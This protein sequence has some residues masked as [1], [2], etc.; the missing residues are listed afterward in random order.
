M[1]LRLF[2][3]LVIWLWKHYDYVR[4]YIKVWATCMGHPQSLLAPSVTYKCM[5]PCTWSAEILWRGGAMKYK[6]W[7]WLLAPF[8]VI[9]LLHLL[10]K[11]SITKTDHKVNTLSKLI[12]GT[13]C[14]HYMYISNLMSPPC[15]FCRLFN[16]H[17]V[18][19]LLWT[20]CWMS[21][22]MY[23]VLHNV[24]SNPGR[25]IIYVTEWW[26]LHYTCKN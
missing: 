17:A 6:S 15:T 9:M 21:K 2:R 7:L 24:S 23:E 5:I 16:V 10:F 8:L 13:Q 1:S 3:Y 18:T 4:S 26:N 12:Q 22:S 14:V 20:E 19:L 25:L 11:V